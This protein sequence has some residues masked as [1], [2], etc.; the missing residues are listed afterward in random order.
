MQPFVVFHDVPSGRKKGVFCG[1]CTRS[2]TRR[3]QDPLPEI[4]PKIT[5]K[6]GEI[7]YAPVVSRSPVAGKGIN[8][9]FRIFWSF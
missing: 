1:S 4:L 9:F 3:E 6:K 2:I 7:Y 8:Y 5:R